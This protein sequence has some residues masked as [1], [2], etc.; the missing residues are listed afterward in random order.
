MRAVLDSSVWVAGFLS[1]SGASHEIILRGLKGEFEIVVSQKIMKEVLKAFR[2][3]GLKKR[4]TKDQISVL[5]SVLKERAR[6]V[7]LK[8]NV[9][10]DP[11]DDDIVAAAVQWKADC[12]VSLDHDLTEPWGPARIVGVGGLVGRNRGPAHGGLAH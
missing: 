3:P 9:V 5:K 12:L 2:K 1:G 7:S 11:Q 8:L 6:K 4:I 10:R